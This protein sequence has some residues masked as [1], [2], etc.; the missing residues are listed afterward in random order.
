MV[1]FECLSFFFCKASARLLWPSDMLIVNC[2]F[3][4]V[5][6]NEDVLLGDKMICHR[7]PKRMSDAKTGE[8][9][10]KEVGGRQDRLMF[11]S[12]VTSDSL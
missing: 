11:Y 2:I 4:A 6:A 9:L 10:L 5:T 8:E 1:N 12:S 3:K 7:P